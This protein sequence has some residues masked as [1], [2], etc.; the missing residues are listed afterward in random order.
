M[1]KFVLIL[2]LGVFAFSCEK[3]DNTSIED[4]TIQEINPL[5]ISAEELEILPSVGY[6]DNESAKACYDYDFYTYTKV[7]G[8]TR[9]KKTKTTINGRIGKRVT[10]P[11]TVSLPNSCWNYSHVKLLRQGNF[12]Y[13]Y[14]I[15]RKNCDEIFCL[16]MISSQNV[17][18]S[19]IPKVKGTYKFVFAGRGGGK[20]E[21]QGQVNVIVK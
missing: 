5:E 10:I 15:G 11:F 4:T 18:Y 14:P 1:K 9:S 3:Q 13:L 2:S 6:V 12:D 16:P 7:N 19:F 17:G 21:I 8:K 20:Y